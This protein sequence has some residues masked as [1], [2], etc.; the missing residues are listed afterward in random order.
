MRLGLSRLQEADGVFALE[1][2]E[3]GAQGFAPGDLEV[4]VAGK[5][6]AGVVPCGFQEV[7]VQF[8]AVRARLPEFH[9]FFCLDNL[10]WFLLAIAVSK[11]LHELGHGLVCKHF[12]GECHE[13]GLMLLVFTPCLYVNVS[14]AWL[15]PNKWHR[16]AISAAGMA[17][18]VLLA[19]VCTFIWW[20]SEPGMLNYLCL[21][22]M[23]IS[24]VSTLVFNANPLLR[25]D[26]YYI[27]SDLMEVPN[28]R[29]KAS[30]SPS[31]PGSR[32]RYTM[33]GR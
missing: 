30:T 1:E 4:R 3:E 22:V 28:L 31:P 33:N 15:L 20:F 19:A 17:V 8:Q 32:K 5:H 26:G 7:A 11:A 21:N 12:G 23:F 24:S 9:A 6:E 10:V 16:I 25:Y 13:L 29:Q 2:V 14:D 27:L 18:E